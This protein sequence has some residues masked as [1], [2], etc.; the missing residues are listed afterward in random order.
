MHRVGWQLE[1]VRSKH[2]RCSYEV[3]CMYHINSM[4]SYLVRAG[5]EGNYVVHLINH[6][7]VNQQQA[8]AH[9]FS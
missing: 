9:K 7:S 1:T 2:E 6:H 3:G 4:F 8:A 5:A